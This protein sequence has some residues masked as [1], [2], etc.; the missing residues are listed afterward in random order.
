MAIQTT[1]GMS[2]GAFRKLSAVFPYARPA[3]GDSIEEIQ[4]REGA[5]DVLDFIRRKML[6]DS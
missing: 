6:D 4:R 3:V 1:K 2:Q 5:E